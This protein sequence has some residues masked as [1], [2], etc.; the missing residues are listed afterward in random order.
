M[1]DWGQWREEVQEFL[2]ETLL[3]IVIVLCVA[4]TAK[5]AEW[6]LPN[7]NKIKENLAFLE[8]Y[9]YSGVIGVLLGSMLLKFIIRRFRGLFWNR[10]GVFAT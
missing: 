9:V 4:A 6:A 7:G 5:V 2:Q 1:A 3:V 8:G 10:H